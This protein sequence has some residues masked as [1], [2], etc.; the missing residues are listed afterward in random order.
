MLL[1][2]WLHQLNIRLKSDFWL[3][4]NATIPGYFTASDSSNELAQSHKHRF[5]QT[6]FDIFTK[7][8]CTAF[9]SYNWKR[10]SLCSAC[11]HLINTAWPPHKQYYRHICIQKHIVWIRNNLLR[12]RLSTNSNFYWVIERGRWQL[13]HRLAERCT[14]PQ[15]QM[16][17]TLICSAA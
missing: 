9:L 17:L 13:K 7:T 1:L 4:G 6:A 5:L 16:T 14:H 12:W 8:A 3:M 11:K 10:Y 15:P 2:N